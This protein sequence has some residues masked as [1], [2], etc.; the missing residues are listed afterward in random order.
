ME[1]AYIQDLL[2][3]KAEEY[4]QKDFVK[5]DPIQIPHQFN[6]KQDI[7]ISALWTSILSWGQRATIIKKCNLLFELMDNAPHDF[8]L[9]HSEEDLKKFLNFKHRTF[10]AEDT[11]YFIDF[12]KRYYTKNES[13]ENIFTS[14]NSIEKGLE[15]L[16]NTFFDIEYAPKRTRKHISSPTTNST[17]KRLNMFL[18]WMVRKDEN[19]VD[20]GIWGNISP[21]DLYCPLDVHVDRVA[22]KLQLIQ[23]KQSDWKTVV[24]L[25]QQLKRIL[26]Q[27][28][29]KLDFALFGLGL[30]KF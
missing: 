4:N 18:R 3:Q 5:D 26:P 2:L 21:A 6:K 23:R 13:L 8:I 29:V 22:R 25:T 20:F 12:F 10:N 17:C 9:N 30:E 1:F 15:N 24:E 28:P 11:L 7:E 14:E 16:K 27:D 19:G